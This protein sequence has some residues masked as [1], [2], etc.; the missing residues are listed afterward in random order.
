MKKS[1]ARLIITGSVGKAQILQSAYDS[2]LLL[3]RV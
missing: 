2:L 1:L 3:F